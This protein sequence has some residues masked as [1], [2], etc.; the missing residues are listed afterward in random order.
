[1]D[2]PRA[3]WRVTTS[4]GRLPERHF[5]PKVRAKVNAAS[6]DRGR[7]IFCIDLDRMETVAVLT[8]H[9]DDD[10]QRP[11]Q[12]TSIGL[13]EDA[14][15]DDRLADDSL[16]G[17]VVAKQYAHAIARSIGR[18]DVLYLDAD[19]DSPLVSQALELL[20]FRRARRVRGMH[21]AARLWCQDPL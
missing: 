10:G 18:S 17:A 3:K 16:V 6:A 12:V 19:E 15:P 14:A 21:P 7:R 13:R 1:M 5:H 8:Y 11:L 4:G 20:G 2:A 9:V